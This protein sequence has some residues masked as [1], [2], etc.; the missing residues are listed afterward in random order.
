MVLSEARDYFMRYNGMGF[1]MCREEPALYE[2]YKKLNISRTMENDWRLEILREI[3]NRFYELQHNATAWIAIG[4]FIEVL[5]S[6]ITQHEDNGKRL[7]KMLEYANENLD[8]RQ[9]I[10][11]MEHMSGRNSSYDGGIKW[12]CMNTHLEGE[13]FT[14]MRR[15]VDFD[16]NFS[17][18][19]EGW[20]NPRMRYNNALR[21]ME[22]AA[23]RYAH[24]NL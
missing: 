15:F 5:F 4:T 1:H 11:I 10:L 20:K 23:K 13:M 14:V 7:L 9:K 16:I 22:N 3:E 19:E 17:S 8:Q 21:D 18:D 6:V 2:Q 12:F 24:C